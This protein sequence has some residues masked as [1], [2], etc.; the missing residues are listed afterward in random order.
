MRKTRKK[1][2][3][4]R[5]RRTTRSTRGGWNKNSIVAL[6][7]TVQEY[8]M[9]QQQLVK[10]LEQSLHGIKSY[11]TLVNQK[12]VELLNPPCSNPESALVYSS[13]TKAIRFQI[14]S[15]LAKEKNKL[16]M[17]TQKALIA[18]Q[19]AETVS[20]YATIAAHYR[21]SDPQPISLLSM[22][23]ALKPIHAAVAT[24]DLEEEKNGSYASLHSIYDQT[25][26]LQNDTVVRLAIDKHDVPHVMTW[27]RAGLDLVEAMK[28]ESPHR[29]VTKES[30]NI[31]YTFKVIYFIAKG[32][33]TRVKEFADQSTT[34]HGGTVVKKD[35]LPCIRANVLAYTIYHDWKEYGL[36]IG[37]AGI[38]KYKVEQAERKLDSVKRLGCITI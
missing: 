5:I 16:R 20:N 8:A 13:C 24:F 27:V 4:L 17:L 2:S 18:N 28:L 23:L 36:E 14:I 35:Q 25:N 33:A 9:K 1:R 10:Q 12:A 29:T 34:N 3:T 31:F 6:R 32:L 21:L 38:T 7:G 15:D 30:S 26:K 19:L 22:E 37:A 11:H